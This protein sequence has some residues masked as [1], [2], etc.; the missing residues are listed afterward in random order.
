M[1]RN[2]KDQ[3]TPKNKEYRNNQI[4]SAF[5]HQEEILDNYLISE[6]KMLFRFLCF[7]PNL[8]P[9]KKEHTMLSGS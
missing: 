2:E 7:S 4:V 6:L 1:K 8:I 3:K 9:T 5:V